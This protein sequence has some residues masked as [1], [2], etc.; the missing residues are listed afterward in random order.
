MR[1]RRPNKNQRCTDVINVTRD[2][3]S[4][5]VDHSVQQHLPSSSSVKQPVQGKSCKKSIVA[6]ISHRVRAHKPFECSRMVSSWHDACYAA[7]PH[8]SRCSR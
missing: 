5:Q 8:L 2:I 6:V 1:S 3:A 4:P 7:H